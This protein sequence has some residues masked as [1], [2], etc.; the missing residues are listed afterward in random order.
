[1]PVESATEVAWKLGRRVREVYRGVVLVEHSLNRYRRIFNKGM[2]E[3]GTFSNRSVK[4][5]RVNLGKGAVQFP[6]SSL[7]FVI[8]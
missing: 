1:M 5:P 3:S 8:L 6:P 7:H 2:S 4:R